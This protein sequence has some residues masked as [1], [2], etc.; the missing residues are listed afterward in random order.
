MER[1]VEGMESSRGGAIVLFSMLCELYRCV[2]VGG[3]DRRLLF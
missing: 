3:F 1:I 2:D